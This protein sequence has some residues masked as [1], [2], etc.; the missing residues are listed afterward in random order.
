MSRFQILLC[1]ETDRT[2]GMFH[3]PEDFV[4]TLNREFIPRFPPTYGLVAHLLLEPASDPRAL[5]VYAG[6]LKAG[7]V[8]IHDNNG[9]AGERD[10]VIDVR[11]G[12]GWVEIMA[13]NSHEWQMFNYHD[14]FDLDVDLTFRRP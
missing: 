2:P 10:R 6:Q 1:G 9:R 14:H 13:T 11:H 8:F 7:D 4:E 12:E 3:L 5:T